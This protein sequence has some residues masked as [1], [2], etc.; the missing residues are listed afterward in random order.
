MTPIVAERPTFTRDQI[1]SATTAA[2]RFAEIRRKAKVEPQFISEHN[3]IDSVVL[4]YETYEQ[5]WRE[6][7]ELREIEIELRAERR[8]RDDAC[9]PVLLEE[10]K[11][12]EGYAE[13]EAIDPELISDAELFE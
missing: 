13:F 7:Y 4:D 3:E 11:G 2:K 9:E 8:L 10:L 6:L 12:P 1:T 5:M